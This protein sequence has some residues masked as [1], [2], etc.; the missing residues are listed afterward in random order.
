MKEI[1]IAETLSR[2]RKEK[3]VTQEE[4][5]RFIGVSKAS[6]SKW[7]T[8]SSYPDVVFLPQLAAYFNISL[9][10]LM[11]YEPQMSDHDIRKLYM[12]LISEFAAKPLDKMLERCREIAKKYYA[13]F[14]LLFQIAVLLLNYGPQA[15]DEAQKSTALAEAKSLFIRIKELSNNIELRRLAL[16]S[17]ALCELM[18]DKPQNIIVL[19]ENE[20]RHLMQPSIETLLSQAHQMLGNL[21]EARIISQGS[22]FDALVSLFYEITSHLSICADDIKEFEAICQRALVL[23]DVF[24]MKSL[25]P[26]PLLSFYISAAQ[27]YMELGNTDNA[28]AMLEDY[29]NLASEPI[30]PLGV[31]SDGFFPLLKEAREKQM[32]ESSIIMPKLPRD[33]QTMKREIVGAVVESPVF[34]ALLGLPRYE[35]LANKLN[36][37]LKI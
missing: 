25:F 35:S 4:L 17:E 37:L 1:H 7:E 31:Q 6:V 36:L 11:G 5:A 29:T 26:L 30:F 10:E 22:V 24:K 16:Q 33:E 2:K 27:G 32:A 19:L 28:L 20:S 8:G 9:D 3:G 14:P 23:A 12:E 15:Q 21:R 18:C 34:S 13:C